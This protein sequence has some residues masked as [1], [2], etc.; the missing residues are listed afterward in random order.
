MKKFK[1]ILIM[2]C[3]MGL[4]LAGSADA[5]SPW[6]PASGKEQNM[7]AYGRVL[8][9]LDFSG[10]GYAL[11]SFGPGGEQDC[12]SKSDIGTDGAYYAT[13]TGDA[14]GDVIRFKILD[15]NGNV[16]D[17]QVSLVFQP[18][19]TKAKFDLR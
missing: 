7:V 16:T 5:A 6:S 11:Y 12:R 3:M 2:V 19:T 18:D 17:L 1:V 4:C 14:A 13:I 10:G 8:G 9:E 15:R